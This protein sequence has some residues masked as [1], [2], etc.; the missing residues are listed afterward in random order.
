M[1][2]RALHLHHF[3]LYEEALFE[4]SPTINVIRGPNARGKTSLLEAIYFLMTGRSFRTAQNSDLIRQGSSFFRLEAHFIK[5]GIEQKLR[6]YYSQKERKIFYN[7][8]P[9]SSPLNL[10]GLLQGIIIHPDDAAIV[11]GAPAVRRHL[12]DL[13]LAQADPLYVHYLTRYDKAMR[14]R[15]HLLKARQAFTIESWEYEMA[16]AAAYVVNQR[17]NSVADLQQKSKELY[18]RICGRKEELG[19][20]YKAHGASSHNPLTTSN[21]ALRSLYS[22]QYAYRSSQRRPCYH[23]SRKRSTLFCQRRTA[24]QLRSGYAAGRMGAFASSL[25]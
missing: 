13:Q 7:S 23:A 17:A 8:T 11:K 21:S 2:L 20:L 12:L 19:L 1:H 15:N 6:I 24:T 14:Q 10:L 25:S 22:D 9:C 16:N 3:R 4:F 5:H 18:S